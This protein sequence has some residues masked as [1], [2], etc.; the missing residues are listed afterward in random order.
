MAAVWMA[1]G[2]TALPAS[3]MGGDYVRDLDQRLSDEAEARLETLLEEHHRATGVKV[4][5]ETRG[6]AGSPDLW[7]GNVEQGAATPDDSWLLLVVKPLELEWAAG[8]EVAGRLDEK[9]MRFIGEKYLAPRGTDH[10]ER[11]DLLVEGVR[12]SLPVIDGMIQGGTPLSYYAWKVLESPPGSPVNDGLQP[13]LLVGLRYLL[14]VLAM[15]PLV[16]LY[17]LAAWAVLPRV[18]LSFA[19][20]MLLQLALVVPIAALGFAAPT[21]GSGTTVEPLMLYAFMGA[22]FFLFATPLHLLAGLR[23]AGVDRPPSWLLAFAYPLFPVAILVAGAIGPRTG[24]WAEMQRQ[25]R[26]IRHLK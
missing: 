20:L 11:P 4:M 3:S 21:L 16:L 5:V 7:Q 13:Y 8:A 1:L 25:F 6:L 23:V 17:L 10:L 19:Q 22:V 12:S 2:M 14:G 15:A 18:R 9:V 24:Q 26:F